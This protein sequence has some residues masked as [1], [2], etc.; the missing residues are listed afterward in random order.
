M[1]FAVRW[2]GICLSCF[3]V[4]LVGR[5]GV[6]LAEGFA[7]LGGPDISALESPLVVPEVQPLVSGQGVSAAEEARWASPTGIVAREDSRTKFEHLTAAQAAA[8][9]SEAFSG[10]IDDVAGGPPRL[11]AGQRITRYLSDNAGAVDLGGDKAALVESLEPMAIEIAPHRRAPID[12]ALRDDGRSFQPTRPVVRVSIPKRLVDGVTLVDTGVSLT[13]VDSSGLPLGGSEGSIVGATVLY[14]NTLADMDSAIKPVTDGFSAETIL[15]SVA[16]TRELFFRVGL[17]AGARLVQRGGPSGAVQVVEDGVAAAT[18]LPPSAEDA[19]GT[20]VPVTM[21]VSGSTLRISV[22][23]SAQEYQYPIEVDPTLIE[24]QLLTAG[25]HHTNWEYHTDNATAFKS[26]E[27]TELGDPVA[28]TYAQDGTY[29]ETQFAYWGYQTQGVS[30]IYQVTVASWAHNANAHLESFLEM[31]H[32]ESEK[33]VT[34]RKALLSTEAE[35]T[36]EYTDKITT[37][38]PTTVNECVPVTGHEHNVVRFQQSAAKSCTACSF[39]DSLREALVYLSEPAG[40]HA[41]TSYNETAPTLEYEVE[42]KK[43]TRANALYKAAPSWLSAEDGALELIGKDAGIGV[44]KTKLEYESAPGKWEQLAEHNYLAENDCKGVQCYPTHGEDWTLNEQLP[45]GEDKIRYKAEDA[46]PATSS[47]ETEGVAT[48]KVDKSK[49]RRLTLNGLPFGNELSERSYSLTAEA[50]DGEG[51]TVA[52][53]GVKSIEVYVDSRALKAT[54]GTGA[55]SVAKGECT[56]SEE[57]AISGSQLGAGHHAI[58]I[59]VKDNA[60]NEAR[61]EEQ[62]SIRHSTPVPIGPGSVDLQSGDFSLNATDVSMGAG[63]VVTRNYSSRDLTAGSHGPLGPQWTLGLGSADSLVELVDG[64]VLMTAA[65]GSQTI[66]AAVLNSEQHP[67]GQFEPPVGDANLALSLEENAEKTAKIAYYLK[68]AADHSVVKFTKVGKGAAAAWVPTTQEGAVPTDTITYKY[69]NPESEQEIEP[70]EELAPKPPGVECFWKEHP[71]EMQPG[72][73]ALEFHYATHTTASGENE[74]EWGEYAGRLTSVS[75]VAYNPATKAMQETAVAQYLWDID[76]RLRAEWDPRLASPLKTTYGYV[77]GFNQDFSPVTSLTPPGEEPW[78]FTYGPTATDP[79]SGRLQKITRGQPPRGAS[80]EEATQKLKEQETPLQ[81]TDKPAI[82]GTPM[83]GVRLAASKG[84]WTGSPVSYTYQW[85]TCPSVYKCTPIVGATNGNYTPAQSEVGNALAVTVTATNGSGTA[86]VGESGRTAKVV[87]YETGHPS[88]EEVPAGAGSTIEYNVPVSG[89]G[90]PH[91]MSEAEVATWGQA[92]DPV[93]ATAIFPEDEP[94]GWPASSYKRATIDYLDEL[95]RMVNVAHPSTAQYGSISTTEYNETND[96]TR[97]LTPDNRATAL[98]AGE[99]AAEV[100]KLLDTENRYN[101][102]ECPAQQPGVNAAV[103]TRLC[104]T[105]G[106]QHEVRLAHPNGH[107]ESEVLARNHAEYFYD[108]GVPKVKPYSEETFNLVT[109]TSDLALAANRE[110]LEVRTTRT[111]YA[112]QNNLGWKLREP[113]SV[114]SEPKSEESNPHGLNL[115]H[116]TLYNE[117]TGQVIEARG[118]GAESTVTYA[119]K[120]GEAGSGAG[121]LNLPFGPALDSKGDIWVADSGNNR[122]EEYSPEGKYVFSFGTKGK[123]AGEL[124]EPKALTIDAKGDVWV[125]ESGNDRIQEFSSEGKSLATCGKSGSGA[126]ALS[127]PKG[128][129]IDAKGDVWIA[130]MANNRIEEFSSECKYV[131]AFGT[132]GT[133]VGQIKEPTGVAI[134]QKGDVWV[135]ERANDRIQEF[136]PE[137]KVLAHFGTLGAGAGQFK[138]PFGIAINS[139]GDLWVTDEGNDRAQELTPTGAF[140]TQIGWKGTEAGQLDEPRSLA[141]DAKGDL[142]V[143]DTGNNRFEEWS[144]GPNAHDSKTVYYSAEADAEYPNCGKEPAWAGLTCE[145]LPAKQPELDGLPKLPI[146]TVTAYNMWLEPEAIEEAFGS[147][148]RIKR[149]TYDEVGRLKTSATTAER[150]SDKTLPKVILEYSKE[151]G[152]LT[153]QALEGKEQTVTSAANRLGQLVKYTDADGNTTNYKYGGPETDDQLEEVTEGHEETK[154]GKET[155]SYQRYYYD[156]TTKAMTKLVDSAAGTFTASYDAELN[157]SSETFPNNM[158]ADYTRN[159]AAETTSVK[160]LKTSNCTENE[161]AVW[162]SDTR[163]PSIHGETLSQTSTLGS[164]NYSWD[165]AGRLTETQETPAGEGCTVR[166]YAY[167]EES[168]RASLTTRKPGPKGECLSEGGTTEAHNYD[169]ANRLTDAEH[170]VRT[171]RERRKTAR[172]GRRRPRAD[173]QLLCR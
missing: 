20:S 107:G 51:T 75:L 105:V 108:E 98:A 56:A 131:S 82:T 7:G 14:A 15:R 124:N 95:G 114:T 38:C 151:T 117:S 78:T 40:T 26:T 72:C 152:L 68:N 128:I 171:V 116:T 142:W 79:G 137:G 100:S 21:S 153:K 126:G 30:D 162:Y 99:K 16:S 3:M 139:A 146:T 52:S 54:G 168:N 106:P 4:S 37:L 18:V 5:P 34:E 61:R 48:I 35:K 94:Q 46:M 109:Q 101:E 44:S 91:N 8:V 127:E 92:D 88:A 138:Q 65:N 121:K 150:S 63:L 33:P 118:A 119:A 147:A 76:G 73:R 158:C 17:P 10:V 87:A 136:S 155:N 170:H 47:T 129:A 96:V 167:D 103:G 39:S 41:T 110:Q 28:E 104:E 84:Q 13:P 55:C 50:T 85:E 6:A 134:D 122:I 42:G 97:T 156:E 22:H 24:E 149:E 86:V 143:A 163:V 141:L 111:S 102:P 140:I 120:F 59:V 135:A 27:R 173:Q 159:S 43:Q 74:S 172:R 165:P 45:N 148:T 49:P 53:S 112:G 144:P 164:E 12:L 58:V 123:K 11:P 25:S 166:A 36:T 60:G 2:L 145:T 160:Y 89:T 69:R 157:M 161:P 29:S 70:A 93:E 83:V 31:Q 77:F 19:A 115:T 169:E 80:E 154:E 62:L 90:A 132:A 133:E 113:T 57:Y 1:R 23:D 71:T 81:N 9:A 32:E 130:D 66:F 64:S 125:S 67:T